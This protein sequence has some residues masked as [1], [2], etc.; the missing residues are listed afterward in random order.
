M[1][2]SAFPS[3]VG[4]RSSARITVPVTLIAQTDVHVTMT[5]VGARKRQLLQQRPRRNHRA[6]PH[7]RPL[8]PRRLRQ[9]PLHH[10]TTSLDC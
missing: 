10:G 8:L 2:I 1:T 4:M 5:R 7:Q 9:L 3:A 6:Q